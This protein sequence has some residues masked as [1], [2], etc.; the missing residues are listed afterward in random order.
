[1]QD[2]AIALRARDQDSLAPL[3]GDDPDAPV[4]GEPH[5]SEDS[6]RDTKSEVLDENEVEPEPE[7]K[8]N[9]KE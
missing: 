3:T 7:L 2:C 9:L 6:T 1:M 8:E 5:C 4:E